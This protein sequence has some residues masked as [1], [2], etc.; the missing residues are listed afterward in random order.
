MKKLLWILPVVLM[1]CQEES[2]QPPKYQLG[3]IVYMK[4]DSSK[5]VV[6]DVQI[7]GSYY[8]Y[9]VD[10]FTFKK[11]QGGVLVREELIF[12]KMKL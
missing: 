8:L 1:S 10:D 4:P 11:E 7:G 3:D 6:S 5:R 12:G 9:Q 2:L